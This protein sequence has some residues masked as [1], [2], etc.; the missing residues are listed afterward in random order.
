MGLLGPASKFEQASES[1]KMQ[2]PS[3]IYTALP[4]R[5]ARIQNGDVVSVALGGFILRLCR[6][7]DQL[8]DR[9]PN[10][11]PPLRRT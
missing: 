8:Q 9:K 11:K 10:T 7:L 3:S 6:I 5:I 4:F 2:L 1:L